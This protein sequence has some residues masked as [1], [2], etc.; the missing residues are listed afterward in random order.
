MP[1]GIYKRPILEERFLKY[2][3][4]TDYCWIWLGSKDKSGYGHF[5]VDSFKRTPKGAHRVSYELNVGEIPHGL[6]VLH[7]CDNP[8]CVNPEHLWLGTKLDNA[9]DKINKGRDIYLRGQDSWASKL[10][11]NKV[12]RIRSLYKDKKHNQTSLSKLFDIHQSSVSLI[13]NNKTWKV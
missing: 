13:V 5:F 1:S 9:K 6:C 4:K 8:S 3:D 2:V 12:K 11:K 7:K 10:T